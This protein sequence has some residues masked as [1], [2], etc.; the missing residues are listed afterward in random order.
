M[1]PKW[2][3]NQ[4]QSVFA[5][6][7]TG[8][9]VQNLTNQQ[10]AK[11]QNYTNQQV[12]RV[13]DISKEADRHRLRRQDVYK[14]RGVKPN[15]IV[16]LQD[17]LYNE[18][19][20]GDIPY[21]KAVDGIMGKM[22]TDALNRKKLRQENKESEINWNIPGKIVSTVLNNMYPYGYDSTNDTK[23]AE[24]TL[25]F[26]PNP[27][28]H[29]A[30]FAYGALSKLKRG[31]TG[32][33][34]GANALKEYADLDL[35]DP[36]NISKAD[37]L[38]NVAIKSEPRWGLRSG[39][40]LR[41]QISLRGRIDQNLLHGGQPQK[42]N[43]YTR[44][45]G[46]VTKDGDSTYTFSDPKLRA[47]EQQFARNYVRKNIHKL[48]DKNDNSVHYA[49]DKKH[50]VFNLR[51]GDPYAQHG[52]FS[53]ITDLD[54]KHGKTMDIWDFGIGGASSNLLPGTKKVVTGIEF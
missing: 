29:Y 49:P 27:L 15:D 33:D 25:S 43:T 26:L 3:P 18:G 34:S 50:I 12:Q 5:T 7:V 38:F 54:G 53:I 2:T 19:Y 21:E 10:R 52:D 11:V 9:N 17:Q 45:Y 8:N 30:S 13:K 32:S 31:I 22:T 14:R 24:K 47:Q 48:Y 46:Y 16:A 6:S 44:Q 28:R 4:N 35:S 20:F 51:G 1:P 37:S 39:S 42:Y 23:V 41:K 36:K 40:H